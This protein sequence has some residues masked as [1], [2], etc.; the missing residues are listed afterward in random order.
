LNIFNFFLITTAPILFKYGM[1][2]LWDKGVINCEFQVSHISIR[3]RIWLNFLKIFSESTCMQ[4][5]LNAWR[6]RAGRCLPKLVNFDTFCPAPKGPW[7]EQTWIYN[8]PES[9]YVNKSSSASVVLEK[10]FLNGPTPFL[11]LS[12]LWRGPDSLL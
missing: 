8:I 5:K 12:P 3:R 4:E 11:W 9:F 10:K 7:F 2:H 1:M 6:C